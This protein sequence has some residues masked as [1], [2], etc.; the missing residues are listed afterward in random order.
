MATNWRWLTS[1]ILVAI[2]EC[3]RASG[4]PDITILNNGSHGN[5]NSTLY[6]LL[7]S[8]HRPPST[9]S[10]VEG[11]HFRNKQEK[12]KSRDEINNTKFI[13]RQFDVLNHTTPLLSVNPISQYLP[14]APSTTGSNSLFGTTNVAKMHIPSDSI[15]SNTVSQYK[16][17]NI[18]SLV[19]GQFDHLRN[20]I[21]ENVQSEH[22]PSPYS[23]ISTYLPKTLQTL[24]PLSNKISQSPN[25]FL[26]NLEDNSTQNTSENSMNFESNPTNKK[27]AVSLAKLVLE[28]IRPILSKTFE[29][30]ALTKSQMTKA[31][32]SPEFLRKDLLEKA[33]DQISIGIITVLRNY[34]GFSLFDILRSISQLN[35]T[36]LTGYLEGLQSEVKQ[37]LQQAVDVQANQ[38]EN[39]LDDGYHIPD[40]LSFLDISVR[41]CFICITLLRECMFA[42]VNECISNIINIMFSYLVHYNLSSS[43]LSNWEIATLKIT[44]FNFIQILQNCLSICNPII[45]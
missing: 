43:F 21:M 6:E 42:R 30:K 28:T 11:S 22:L 24:Y 13:I 19:P 35:P 36:L 8:F 34:S 38:R 17:N 27:K 5:L 33:T 7:H 12:L 15:N 44:Y 39:G 29:S 23:D 3:S 41:I 32:K 16:N 20:N 40:F 25:A 31:L 18:K 1:V 2:I 45:Y 26:G 9:H 4:N 10:T 37:G 14:S